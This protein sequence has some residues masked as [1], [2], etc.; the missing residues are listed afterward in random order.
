VSLGPAAFAR[1]P[2][3]H[4]V[5]ASKLAQAIYCVK[6]KLR[7]ATIRAGTQINLPRLRPGA[8]GAVEENIGEDFEGAE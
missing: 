5:E 7:Q 3:H 4:S 8:T 6:I 2:R 1:N